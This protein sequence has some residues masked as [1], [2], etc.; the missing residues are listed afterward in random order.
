MLRARDTRPGPPAGRRVFRELPESLPVAIRDLALEASEQLRTRRNLVFGHAVELH[1]ADATIRFNPLQQGSPHVEVPVRWS[2]W[3]E[4]A[5]A[6][7]RLSG[8]HDPLH[9]GFRGLDD[10]SAVVRGWLV[11]LIGYARIVCRE[12]LIDLVRPHARAPMYVRSASSGRPKPRTVTASPRA[13]LPGGLK[14][15]GQTARWMATYVAGHR[16]RLQRG[17]QA[18]REA[19]AR[20]ARVGIVLRPGETWVS[21]FVRGVPRDAVIQFQWEGPVELQVALA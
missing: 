20:A 4:D 8:A 2:H 15:V 5:T 6:E 11:A 3:S 14:P 16:R 10:E 12:D 17:H 21:P 7:L 9:L 13:A 19:R 18:S 1:Y